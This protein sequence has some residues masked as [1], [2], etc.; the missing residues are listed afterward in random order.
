MA[1]VQAVAA[2]GAATDR[3]LRRA[4]IQGLLADQFGAALVNDA[5]FQAVADQVTDAI[6]A[7]EAASALLGKVIAELAAGSPAKPG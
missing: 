7:D 5:K 3:Q 6:G 4:V 2:G 1:A